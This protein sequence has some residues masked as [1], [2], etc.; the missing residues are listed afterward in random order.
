M[1]QNFYHINKHQQRTTSSLLCYH[2]VAG[3]QRCL[4]INYTHTLICHILPQQF[5]QS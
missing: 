4:F 2:H 3:S 1:M 5:C